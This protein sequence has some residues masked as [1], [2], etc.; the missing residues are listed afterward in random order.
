[1]RAVTGG[2]INNPMPVGTCPANRVWN[3]NG[4]TGPD[5]QEG[6]N[7]CHTASSGSTCA[8]TAWWASRLC[9]CSAA[10]EAAQETCAL[11]ASDCAEAEDWD[12]LLKQCKPSVLECPATGCTQEFCCVPITSAP[13]MPTVPP[14]SPPTPETCFDDHTCPRN[15]KNVDADGN[16]RTPCHVFSTTY[17]DDCTDDRCCLA[18]S[19]SPTESPTQEPTESPTQEPTPAVTIWLPPVTDSPTEL[20]T[21]E[22]T[23][24]FVPTQEPTLSLTQEPSAAPTATPWFSLIW[25]EEEGGAATTVATAYPAREELHQIIMLN[26]Q[27]SARSRR[28]EERREMH[29]SDVS[30]LSPQVPTNISRARSL[31]HTLSLF[32][33][34]ARRMPPPRLPLTHSLSLSHTHSVL[35]CRSS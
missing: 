1:M 9:C 32:S 23:L 35:S 17:S 22:P 5:F 13:S 26:G 6:A 30:L 19:V 24:S 15:F 25:E 3:A 20:P 29:E 12:S 27:V 18:I 7:G 16:T 33:A 4:I 8:A 28:E 2:N 21:Q 31:S 11:S 10:D 14:T 34:S